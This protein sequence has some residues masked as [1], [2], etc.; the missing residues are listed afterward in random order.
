M[1]RA[2]KSWERMTC[3]SPVMWYRWLMYFIVFAHDLKSLLA[4][5]VVQ[6]PNVLGLTIAQGYFELL[7]FPLI[8]TSDRSFSF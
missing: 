5:Y 1:L 4:V 8:K 7:G 6:L 3:Y 2:D